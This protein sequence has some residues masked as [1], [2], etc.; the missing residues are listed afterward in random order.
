MHAD[1]Y[2][3]AYNMAKRAVELDPGNA[4]AWHNIGKCYHERQKDEE[5]D[6]H[7]YKAIQ[8]NPGFYNALEGLS[9]SSINR[10]EFEKAIA[11]SNRA[12]AENHDALEARTN[13]AMAY[14]ALKRWREGWR[15]YNANIG[16]EK[17]RKEMVY[18]SEPRWDGTKGLNVACYGEQGIGDELSFASCL[19]D[20]IR[21]SKSVTIECD[22]R[23][24]RV[25]QRSFP[26]TR[27]CGTRYKDERKWVKDFSCDARVAIGELPSFYRLKD[28]D[29]PG[30]PYL[31]PR[32]E[33]ALQWKTLL[34][35]LGD[36]PKI[37]LAWTGGIPRTGQHRRT[38]SL[39][40]FAP[41]FRGFDAEWVSLQYKDVEDIPKAE[42]K[43][44]IKIHDWD[45]GT[46]VKDY[47]QTIALISE[48]DL[49]ISVCTTVVHAAGG[50]GKECWCLVPEVP[51][52]RYLQAG[53][54]FPWASSVKLHRQKNKQWPIVPLLTKLKE[55]W[56]AYARNGY[57]QSQIAA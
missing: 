30:T 44:G 3:L 37:G 7:F 15:D 56:P 33:M 9:L 40:T 12:L 45:W 35:T 32:P 39:D 53:E 50:L 22:W 36:K 48:L 47:D 28:S 29:F 18:G 55:K 17:N 1:S 25:L 11:Y 16:R 54:W 23:V 10:G 24:E 34:D 8:V 4:A 38:M 26:T 31:L 57:S 52:W 43:Y 14:L 20:L 42:E 49:V 13:R 51:M 46:R 5:A 2:G 6:R 41:L 21:D 19:P 27:V